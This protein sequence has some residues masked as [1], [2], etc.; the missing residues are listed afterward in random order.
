M[1]DRP[2][3]HSV[4]PSGDGCMSKVYCPA[5]YCPIYC[6]GVRVKDVTDVGEVTELI[7]RLGKP[8]MLAQVYAPCV[9]VHLVVIPK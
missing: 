6:A 5:L 2:K 8:F 7:V 1:K 4:V 3:I 9:R